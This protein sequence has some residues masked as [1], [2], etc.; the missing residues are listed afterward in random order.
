[1]NDSATDP[2]PRSRAHLRVD[3]VATV[4]LSIATLA[5]AWAGYQASR[6]HSEQALAQ[7]SATKNRIESTKSADTANRE[8]EVDVALFI[9]WVNARADGATQLTDFYRARFTDRFKPFFRTWIASKP[10]TNPKAPST[11]FAIPRYASSVTREAGSLE[12]QADSDSS[13]AAEDIERADE[14]VLAVVLFAACLFFA[15]LSTRL[16]TLRGQAVVLSLGCLL[17]V[18]TGIWVATLPATVSI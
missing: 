16:S 15:G 13:D 14:Y 11:P 3:V 6:W 12:A 4:L 8:A 2:S 1:M 10:F 5:T 7:T 9:Q 17:F 18:G